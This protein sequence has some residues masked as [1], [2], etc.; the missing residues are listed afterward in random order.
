MEDEVR[1]TDWARYL[2]LRHISADNVELMGEMQSKRLEDEFDTW[3]KV[4]PKSRQ[5][6]IA[7]EHR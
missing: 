4:K 1:K 6:L 5:F 3:R 2:R 7:D